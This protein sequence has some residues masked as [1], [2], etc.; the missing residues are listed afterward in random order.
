MHS[1]TE[2]THFNSAQLSIKTNTAIPKWYDVLKRL[3]NLPLNYL[4]PLKIHHI[5]TKQTIPIIFIHPYLY[6]HPYTH[7]DSLLSV[8]REL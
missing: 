4:H 6:P 3:K 1:P 2:F 5:P 8:S 7:F